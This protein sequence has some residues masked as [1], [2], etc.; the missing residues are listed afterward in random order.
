MAQIRR[1]FLYEWMEGKF[2]S[3]NKIDNISS[4][5][6]KDRKSVPENSHL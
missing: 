6:E 3:K 1:I 5:D 4:A 2:D